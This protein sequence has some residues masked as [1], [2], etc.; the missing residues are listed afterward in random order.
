M[1]KSKIIPAALIALC[2]FN[3]YEMTKL[4]K[5]IHTPCKL[6]EDDEIRTK[7]DKRKGAK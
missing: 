5:M 3:G 7:P 1:K 6:I 4:D 2:I